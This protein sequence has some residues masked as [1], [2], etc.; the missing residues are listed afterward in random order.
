[1]ATCDDRHLVVPRRKPGEPVRGDVVRIDEA[2]ARLRH[3]PR[4]PD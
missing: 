3:H 2:A 4:K 1:M